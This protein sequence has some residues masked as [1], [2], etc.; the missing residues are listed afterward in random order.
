M[1]QLIFVV[2]FVSSR[3]RH[4][5]LQ[6]EWSSDVCSSDLSVLAVLTSIAQVCAIVW[7]VWTFARGPAT[8]ERLVVA[9]AAAIAAC[10]AFNKVFSPQFMIWL[11]PVVA[12]VRGWW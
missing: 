10:M 4:T 7:V 12:L 5:R 3:R 9:A 6:G 1:A 8:K 2:F 11:V